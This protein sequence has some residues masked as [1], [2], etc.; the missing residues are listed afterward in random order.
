MAELSSGPLVEEEFPV[1]PCGASSLKRGCVT[2]IGAVSAY[3][4]LSTEEQAWCAEGPSKAWMRISP[5]VG[6]LK[7]TNTMS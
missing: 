4:V 5:S 6:D 2:D 7:D 1:F 3:G